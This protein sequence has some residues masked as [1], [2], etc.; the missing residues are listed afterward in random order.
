M[1]RITWT[2]E[3]K[4][5]AIAKLTEYLEKYG[6]GECICQSDEALIEAPDILADIADEILIDGE[7]IIFTDDE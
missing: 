3:K 4:E 7:G 5:K 6:I 1:I 2:P